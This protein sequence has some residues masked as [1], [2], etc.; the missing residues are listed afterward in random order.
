MTDAL[1]VQTSSSSSLKHT[2]QKC[3]TP[4]DV[5]DRVVPLLSVDQDPDGSI[6]SLALVR[7]SRQLIHLDNT[8]QLHRSDLCR[9][10]ITTTT[11]TTTTSHWEQLA[12]TLTDGIV[13]TSTIVDNKDKSINIDV[14]V[15]AIKSI[16]VTCRILPEL[17]TIWETY[18]QSF[19]DYCCYCS[20]DTSIHDENTTIFRP[21]QLSGL[22][23]AYDSLALHVD[24][25]QE[26]YRMPPTLQRLYESLDL[27][28]RVI[29]G[30]LT[31]QQQRQDTALSVSSLVQQVAFRVDDIRTTSTGKVVK[32]RRQTAWE[33]DNGVP[34]FR[35]SGKAMETMP[36]SPLVRHVRTVLTKRTNQYYDCCLLNHY[37]DG[38]SGMRYH[39][40]PDQGTLW[41]YATAVVSV[42]ATRRFAFRAIDNH[43]D[44]DNNKNNKPHNFVL[45][46]G[47]V[48]EMFGDCQARFQ[49][50]VKTADD[51][52]EKAARASLVFKRTWS[53]RDGI[54]NGVV[55]TT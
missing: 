46:D 51:K 4:T 52:K 17:T 6:A 54:D 10:T 26:T 33:G 8:D 20:A 16:A 34:A 19:H 21:D 30:C 37:P 49:H 11:T 22:Q 14:H 55:M 24:D 2:L 23:W 48:T 40:D 38:G 7:L 42:G 41:D 27:P 35:Y 39:I 5:L 12:Q 32:E 53:G 9:P 47:D 43:N 28:F 18:L 29:P 45:F 44:D 15:E 50:T 31:Q 3:Y 36:W 25:P 1:S 13:S